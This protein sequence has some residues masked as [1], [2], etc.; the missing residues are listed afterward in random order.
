LE[1]LNNLPEE[2]KHFNEILT[3]LPMPIGRIIKAFPEND[4]N[5]FNKAVIDDLLK[6]MTKFATTTGN[7]TTFDE[8]IKF[9]INCAKID[10][11]D[12]FHYLLGA[13]EVEKL[14]Q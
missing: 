5:P 7:K 4:Q 10:G 1:S 13:Y 8:K 6:I 2:K 9:V 12:I 14:W 11:Y 3:K